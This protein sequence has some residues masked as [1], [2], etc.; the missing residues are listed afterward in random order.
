MWDLLGLLVSFSL[1]IVLIRRGRRFGVA[2]LVASGVLMIF[3]QNNLTVLQT[4]YVFKDAVISVDT[5]SLTVGV[6]LIGILANS[7]KHRGQIES[8]ISNL[9]HRTRE[10]GVLAAIPAVFG[11]LP[12]PGGALMSAPMI[13]GEGKRLGVSKSGRVFLNLW[14]RH[15]GFLIF[16]LAPPLLLIAHKSSVALHSLILFQVPIFLG[17][18]IVGVI[19]LFRETKVETDS[20]VADFLEKGKFSLFNSLAPI[21]TSILLFF[22]FS[23]FTPLSFYSSLVVSIPV[24]ILVS[25]LIGVSEGISASNIIK[26]GFSFDLSLAVFGILIFYKI[27]QSSGLSITLSDLFLGSFLPVPA[28][29]VII[30]F[31]LGFSMGHNLGAVGVSYSILASSVSGSLPFVSLIYVSSFLGY[32]ISPIHLCVAVNYEYFNPD[33]AKLYKLYLPSAMT[34][35]ALA[36]IWILI[37][38]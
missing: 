19:I 3:S 31:L 10:E 30:S 11:L 32:L 38:S 37:F 22:L 2:M 35:L 12:V 5:I 29:I 21:S 6:A 4:F 26:E 27:V 16:P 14:F 1:I 23:Y 33:M 34:V 17:A 8:I 15:I 24:G 28:L 25:L 20:E 9:R 18:L 36:V 13:D 7:M